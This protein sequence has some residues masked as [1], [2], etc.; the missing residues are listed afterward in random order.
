MDDIEDSF[1]KGVLPMTSGVLNCCVRTDKY[2]AQDAVAIPFISEWKREAIGGRRVIK[3]QKVKAANRSRAN[4][5][6]GHLVN[7]L[8]FQ[9]D[10]LPNDG[11]N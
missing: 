6:N 10:Y 7:Q 9:K 11:L 8:I 5:V 2:V 3:M 4:E 1:L